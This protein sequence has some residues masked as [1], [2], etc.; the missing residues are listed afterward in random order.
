MIAVRRSLLHTV[1]HAVVSVVPT[2]GGSKD[3]IDKVEG[4]GCADAKSL[5]DAIT[6]NRKEWLSG[7]DFIDIGPRSEEIA[8]ARAFIQN[9]NR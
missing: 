1:Y 4:S 9:N 3:P 8:K 2:P 6:S 5:E 7:V